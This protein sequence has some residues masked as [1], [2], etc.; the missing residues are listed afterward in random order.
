M[1]EVTMTHGLVVPDRYLEAVNPILQSIAEDTRT[2][3]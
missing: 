3:R 1:R 2:D